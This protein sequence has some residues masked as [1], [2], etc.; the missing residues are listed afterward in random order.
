M[1]RLFLFLCLAFSFQLGMAQTGS[2]SGF[3]ADEETKEGLIGAS[4]SIYKSGSKTPITGSSTDIDGSYQIDSL[5]VGTYDIEFSYVGYY[6]KKVKK[7]TLFD[8][9]VFVLNVKMEEGDVEYSKPI[10][11]CSYRIPSID[12]WNTTTG[13]TIRADDIKNSPI[14][15]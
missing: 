1:K 9:K 13:K 5:P 15:W 2:L 6:S 3:V 8:G 12:F 11:S 14:K 7:V 10:F 4:I